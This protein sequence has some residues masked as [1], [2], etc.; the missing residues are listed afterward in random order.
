MQLNQI[1]I[2]ELIK[3]TDGVIIQKLLSAHQAIRD[4]NRE[5]KMDARIKAKQKEMD[6]LKAPFRRRILKQKSIVSAAE[7]V[8]TS[9]GLIISEE[10]DDDV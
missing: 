1:G 6:E 9:R 7:L 4:I 8:A 5:I 3:E 2:V 10:R